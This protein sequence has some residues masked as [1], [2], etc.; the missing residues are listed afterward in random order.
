MLDCD[1]VEIYG[2]REQ[3]IFAQD[4]ENILRECLNMSDKLSQKQHLLKLF[5]DN[6]NMITLGMIMKTDLACEYRKWISILRKDPQY[7][8]P[9][10]VL[11]NKNPSNNLYT[12]IKRDSPISP[13]ETSEEKPKLTHSEAEYVKNKGKVDSIHDKITN[14]R[15][16]QVAYPRNHTQWD[17]IE[18]QIKR[19]EGKEGVNE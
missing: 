12:L 17:R 18:E 15:K 14:Y 16:I 8:I 6:G 2:K 11:D 19:L 13:V 10:P 7:E 3:D 9:E 4:V 5:R 1:F